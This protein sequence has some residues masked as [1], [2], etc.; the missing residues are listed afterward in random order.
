MEKCFIP[1]GFD[2]VDLIK[3][4]TG[5][6]HVPEEFQGKFKAELLTKVDKSSLLLL[7]CTMCVFFYY[8]LLNV[9]LLGVFPQAATAASTDGAS[10]E[11]DES[12]SATASSGEFK[13]DIESEQVWLQGL[14]Q[15]ILQGMIA[16][17]AKF[18]IET[19]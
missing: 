13:A 16:Y 14:H 4:S 18:M 19:L 2:T 1:A 9:Y 12:T 8:L 11:A 6:K 17:Y 5:I 7:S 15:F 3:I 10:T